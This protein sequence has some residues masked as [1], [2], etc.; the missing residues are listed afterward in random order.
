VSVD[1]G[2]KPD[3]TRDGAASA[4]DATFDSV[5]FGHATQVSILISSDHFV[6]LEAGGIGILTKFDP[7]SLC[8]N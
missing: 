5:L 3:S 7:R 4:P 2:K 6:P 1:E 8:E